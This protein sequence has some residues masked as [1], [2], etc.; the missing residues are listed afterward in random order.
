MITKRSITQQVVD[1]FIEQIEEGSWKV[2][3]KIASENV[4]TKELGV[5][6]TSLRAAIQQFV[7]VGMMESIHGKGTFLRSNDLTKLKIG[8]KKVKKYDYLDMNSLLEFRLILE[9]DSCYYATQRATD[10]N[11][12]KL[13]S[14]LQQMKKSV[15][16]PKEFVRYDM[17]FHMEIV[18]A[19]GNPLLEN[20]LKDVFAQK[21]NNFKDF[22]EAFGYKDGIYYHTLLLKAIEAKDASLAKR[23]MRAHLQKAIDDIYYENN[24]DKEEQEILSKL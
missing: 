17:L 1:Y 3:E 2:G 20:A 8:A 6:R 12:E 10:E 22:N 16:N 11:I 9:T 23:I 13:H 24:V 14:Y 4:L 21:E 18:H 7:G 15:G 19:T 5:S